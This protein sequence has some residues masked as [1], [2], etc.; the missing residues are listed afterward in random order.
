MAARKSGAVAGILRP[1]PRLRTFARN[2]EPELCKDLDGVRPID[3]RLD[4]LRSLL[5]GREIHELSRLSKLVEDPF[6][7]PL[8]ERVISTCSTLL[9][10][11]VVML[12]F[13][14]TIAHEKLM[15]GFALAGQPR[16]PD[17]TVCI[18]EGN[19]PKGVNAS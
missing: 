6:A 10:E 18:A 13:L 11:K 9:S 3:P 2:V 8:S 5:L 12:P 16:P 17:K 4:Q 14:S 7:F 1:S 19:M 15:A